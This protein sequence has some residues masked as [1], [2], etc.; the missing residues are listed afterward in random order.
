MICGACGGF[1]TLP[2]RTRVALAQEMLAWEQEEWGWCL[3]TLRWHSCRLLL[4]LSLIDGACA[5]WEPG[6]NRLL[7]VSVR[8]RCGQCQREAEKLSVT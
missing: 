2:C 6:R 4:Q 7:V 1:G 5:V 8:G 3:L